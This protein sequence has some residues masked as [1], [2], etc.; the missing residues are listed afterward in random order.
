MSVFDHIKQ[1]MDNGGTEALMIAW[2]A[3]CLIITWFFAV[4]IVIAESIKKR[5]EKKK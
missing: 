1:A 4:P 2:L 5:K 3:T